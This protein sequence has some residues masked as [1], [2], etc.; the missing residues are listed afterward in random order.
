MAQSR[1]SDAFLLHAKGAVTRFEK[2]SAPTCVGFTDEVTRDA[3]VEYFAKNAFQ[4]YAFISTS[5]DCQR[6]FLVIGDTNVFDGE[7]VYLRARPDKFHA[8]SHKDY[9]GAVMN[10]GLERKMFGDIIVTDELNAFFTVWNKGDILAFLFENLISC[11]RAKIYL[12]QVSNKDFEMLELQYVE[13]NVLATSLRADCVVS[14]ITGMSRSQS[15]EFILSGGLKLNSQP[16][17][18]I[19]RVFSQGDVFSLKRYG[20][21][22]FDSFLGQSRRDRMRIRL[23]KYGNYIERK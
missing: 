10:L 8:P 7:I 16:V 15:K 6:Q 13:T 17:L 21:Y 19:D 18:D 3:C 14:A 12:E 4:D 11:G 20:K 1:E 23:L 5:K 2:T 22:R 9:M